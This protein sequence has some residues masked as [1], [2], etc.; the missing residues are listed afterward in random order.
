LKGS[1]QNFLKLFKRKDKEVSSI[2]A[3]IEDEE[4]LGSKHSKQVKELQSHADELDEEISTA[5]FFEGDNSNVLHKH[6]KH[7]FWTKQLV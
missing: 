7:Y 6:S 4:T 2:A 1:T 5:C 3:K